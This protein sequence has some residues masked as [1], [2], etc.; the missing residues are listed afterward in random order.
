MIAVQIL[1]ILVALVTLASAVL[2]VSTRKLLHAALWLVLTLVG[3]AILFAFL[4]VAFFAVAQILVYVGAIAILIIFAVMLTRR[5]M[6]D[7]GP[8]VNKGWGWAAAGAV[9]LFAGLVV[10]LTTFNGFWAKPKPLSA[11]AVDL[12]AL[13]QALVSPQGYVI[14]FEVA[15]I[16]LLA[17]MVG[18]LV[19]A[20]DR[21]GGKA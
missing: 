9:G 2:V 7:V 6:E 10:V 4:D 17:A 19:V 12:A 1:F 18:A 20:V 15:S 21:K 13:G 3:V 11:E 16:L 5:I 8:Q 14:P